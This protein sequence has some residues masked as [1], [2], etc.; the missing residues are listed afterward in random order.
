[1]TPSRKSFVLLTL[2]A[3]FAAAAA[4]FV[5]LQRGPSASQFAHLKDP[6]ISRMSDQR[7]LVVTA[8]GDPNT[9]AGRAFETLFAA[10]YKLGGV[11]K[12][13]RP[14]APRARWRVTLGTPRSEWQ[15][16]YGLPVPTGFSAS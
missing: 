13:G 7:M 2:A 16:E 15:G 9:V 11:S 4:A 10:Y 1:M 12:A 6:R 8:Q 5:W 3:L 14:P